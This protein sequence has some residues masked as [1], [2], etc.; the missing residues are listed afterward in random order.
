MILCRKT[1]F[2]TKSREIIL[3]KSAICVIRFS[4]QT[5][6][7]LV[8][9]SRVTMASLWRAYG[10]YAAPLDH[11]TDI[12]SYNHSKLSRSCKRVPEQP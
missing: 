3:W 2:K 4:H 7:V 6:G 10:A 8:L 5:L 12:Q 9:A 11:R 1:K